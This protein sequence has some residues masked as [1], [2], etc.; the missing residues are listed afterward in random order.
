MNVMTYQLDARSQV[1]NQSLIDESVV[2]SEDACCGILD[3]TLLRCTLNLSQKTSRLP[4]AIVGT[5]VVDSDIK[6]VTRQKNDR[7]FWAHFINC[8]FSGVFSGIDFG[9]SH[10]VERDGDFGAVEHCDFSAATLD[11]CRFF[12]VEP[13]TLIFPSKGHAVLIDLHKRAGDV[14][15]MSWP[16]QLGKYMEIAADM[17]PSLRAQV[18]HIPSL[19]RLVKCSQDEVREALGRFGGIAM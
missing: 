19:A 17:P 16:G 18:L 1:R 3:S 15:G 11:G 8:R 10:N 5:S 14:A 9:R 6:A 13:S 4:I 12:N 2:L 7:L